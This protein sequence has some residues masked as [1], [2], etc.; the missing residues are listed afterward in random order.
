MKLDKNIL[1]KNITGILCGALIL[2]FLL[3][4][5]KVNVDVSTALGSA[6][7]ESPAMNG[8]KIITEGGF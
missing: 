3:P 6:S 5:I 7:A 8:I 1:I 2:C 4:F